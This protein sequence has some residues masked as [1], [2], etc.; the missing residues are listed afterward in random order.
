MTFR[1]RAGFGLIL[2]GPFTTLIKTHKT[3]EFQS[4]KCQSWSREYKAR[5]Q[6]HGHKKIQGQ[7]PTFREQTLS[8]SRTAMLEAKAKNQE[9]NAP[10]LSKIKKGYRAKISQNFR[11]IQ[12]FSKKKRSS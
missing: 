2:A 3:S 10:V 5:G 11:E 6:G 9:H 1:V 4:C 7:G 12:A 8:R